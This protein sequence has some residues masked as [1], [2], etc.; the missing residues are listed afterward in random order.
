MC[1]VQKPAINDYWST[2]IVLQ[3]VFAKSLLS[4]DRFKS[5]LSMLHLNDNSSY[6]PITHINHDPLHKIRP[7]FDSFIAACSSSFYPGQ[8]LTIDEGICPFRGRIHFKVYIP[9]KPEKYGIKLYI[10]SDASTG[11]LLNCEVYSGSA[12]NKKNAIQDLVERLCNK[13]LGK[14]HT[15]YMDRFYTSPLVFDYLWHNK[16]L[17]V[18][19]VM[20]RRKGLPEVFKTSNL[21]KGEAVFQRKNHLLAVKWR[22]TRDVFMLSSKHKSTS[23]FVTVKSKGGN[24]QKSKPDVVIDYNMYKTGVDHGDQLVAYYPFHR[25]TMK[26]WKKLFF[27]LFSRA[28]VNSFILYKQTHPDKNCQLSSFII[29]LAKALAN[30]GDMEANNEVPP[31]SAA[32][33]SARHFPVK[34][35]PT[36]KKA[37]PTRYCKVCS[38]R[39]KTQAG[40]RI[41]KESRYYCKDCGV[42]LCVPNCFRLFHTKAKYDV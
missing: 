22:D 3:S 39:G 15:I 8:N 38:D 33:L 16:T 11:Y 35:P 36:A 32:R 17:A 6:V 2:D 20:Q 29:A 42:A 12:G 1:V 18:G 27:H 25:K 13:Y 40:K 34:I 31:S 23:S 28:I 9:S 14:G 21:K 5:I 4:R 41:R 7:F 26:W 10:V 24:I 19:T 30:K 37:N